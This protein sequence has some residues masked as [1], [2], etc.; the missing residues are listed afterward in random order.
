MLKADALVQSGSSARIDLGLGRWPAVLGPSRIR[1]VQSR[2]SA[3]YGIVILDGHEP[4]VS[5]LFAWTVNATP[6]TLLGR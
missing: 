3:G 4:W 5:V 1:F 6:N 2:L